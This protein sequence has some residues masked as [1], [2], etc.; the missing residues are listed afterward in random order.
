MRFRTTAILAGILVALFAVVYW[1]D[2][3]RSEK[4][5]EAKEK[6]EK[7]LA[8]EPDSIREILIRPSGIRL[9]KEGQEWTIT[10]PI[11][12]AADKST[13][14]G[15]LGTFRWAKRYRTVA[16][17][18]VRFADYGLEPP[19][20]EMVLVHNAGADTLHIGEKTPTGSYV[21]ARLNRENRVFTTTTSLLSH[22]QK[23]LY[24]L[25]DKRVLP[26]EREK[27]TALHLTNPHGTFELTR[28]GDRWKIR[29]PLEALADRYKLDDVLSRIRNAT[30]REFV[31]EAPKDLAAYGLDK[32]YVRVDLILGEEG[33][34]KTLL[35]GKKK[36]DKYYAHDDGRLPV[37]LVD[38]SFVRELRL[39]LTDLRE[40]KLYEFLSTDVDSTVL[41]Y[42]ELTIVCAKDS[43]GE[44]QVL[45]PERR[46]A[47]NWR[48]SSIAGTVNGLRAKEFI[49]ERATN[50][51]AYG[52]DRPAIRV[53]MFRKGELLADLRIGK[54]AKDG[55]Y[56]LG[57]PEGP[58]ILVAENTLDQLKFTLEDIAEPKPKP[59]E[60]A[61]T[62]SAATPS[63]A[64]SR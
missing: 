31:D 50:L 25:R 17:G 10:E 32:P 23:T 24:N 51:A 63:G 7:V 56:A 9:V 2:V 4:A 40:K 39:T 52:L 11:R 5:K 38:S 18:N 37:F 43:A 46:K 33:A 48:L 8:A 26:F 22:A 62:E 44:W 27:V 13:V 58:V 53:K 20:Y 41:M 47:K 34:R 29:R 60:E 6:E 45:E 3:K 61:K 14:E 64:S 1:G 57:Q 19:Q 21:F 55:V 54:K 35:I 30:A 16:E 12:T 42:P 36:D 28:E 15:V 59:V 49:S